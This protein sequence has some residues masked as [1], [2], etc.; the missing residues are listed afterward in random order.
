MHIFETGEVSHIKQQI[1]MEV[2]CD[3]YADW[4]DLIR[5]VSENKRNLEDR[6]DLIEYVH[7][8][9]CVADTDEGVTIED[10]IRIAL[11]N[12]EDHI[13]GSWKSKNIQ[14]DFEDAIKE[15]RAITEAAEHSVMTMVDVINDARESL[16]L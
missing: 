10:H 14:R 6:I 3:E 16:G 8:L 2:E 15:I 12:I 7:D 11:R 1:A 13:D 5:I 4:D 9:L